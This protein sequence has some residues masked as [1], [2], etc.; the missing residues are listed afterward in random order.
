MFEEHLLSPTARRISDRE[1]GLAV[2]LNWYRSLPLECLEALDISLDGI[3]VAP[4]GVQ[5]GDGDAR[6]VVGDHAGGRW[7]RVLEPIC[8]VAATP[9][10][11]AD[12]YD[13]E[14]AIRTRI[15]YFPPG[16]DGRIPA[17]TNVARRRVEVD[18]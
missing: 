6:F 16:P 4:S 17:M 14:L 2:R 5:L 12:A 15:P 9:G 11:M 7:W 18:Q 3:P 1:I 13:V 10:P 8:V